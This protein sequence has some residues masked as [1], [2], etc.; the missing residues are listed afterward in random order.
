MF[1]DKK[2]KPPNV[3]VCV[4]D[5]ICCLVSKYLMNKMKK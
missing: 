4:T 5:F 2:D 3:M 1:K